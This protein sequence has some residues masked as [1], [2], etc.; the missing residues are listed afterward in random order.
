MASW[1]TV[2]VWILVLCAGLSYCNV[3]SSSFLTSSASLVE[4]RVGYTIGV[5]V[6]IFG[7]NNTCGLGN[8]HGTSYPTL[9]VGKTSAGNIRLGFTLVSGEGFS[10][11]V[12]TLGGVQGGTGG[13]KYNGGV[14]NRCVAGSPHSYLS[15]L[16]SFRMLPSV[17]SCSSVV[18][19]RCSG[20]FP[21]S[22]CDSLFIAAMTRSSG[23]TSGLMMYLC[24]W[25][26]VPETRVVFIYFVHMIQVR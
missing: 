4:S 8:L 23:V 13:L 7:W 22:S 5:V 24:L 15:E 2:R 12:G 1:A 18:L 19:L 20:I 3:S 21:F 16:F 11:T 25:N 17:V 26:T 10:V 9:F 6:G 14:V